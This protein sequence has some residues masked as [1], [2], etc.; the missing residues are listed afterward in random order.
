M[1][2]PILDNRQLTF[3]V[4]NFLNTYILKVYYC[5]TLQLCSEIHFLFIKMCQKTK[6]FGVKIT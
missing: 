4:M 3:I 1:V 6:T 5:S 2:G